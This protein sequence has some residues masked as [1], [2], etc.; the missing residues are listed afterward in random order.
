MRLHRLSHFKD[1]HTTGKLVRRPNSDWPRLRAKREPVSHHPSRSVVRL[2]QFRHGEHPE[3][4]VRRNRTRFPLSHDFRRTCVVRIRPI[5]FHFALCV[6]ICGRELQPRS[7]S[8]YLSFMRACDVW[9]RLPYNKSEV[10]SALRL[11]LRIKT[12]SNANYVWCWYPERALSCWDNKLLSTCMILLYA[13]SLIC[14]SF[15]W[16]KR[17]T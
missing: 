15:R 16:L 3:K 7:A 6:W 8:Q 2:P 11:P 4:R 9:E 17:E 13:D 14:L 1:E 10:F 5:R 12:I